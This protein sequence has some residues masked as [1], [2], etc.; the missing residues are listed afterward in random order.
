[1]AAA[2]AP[3]ELL[4]PDLVA[5]LRELDGR[6]LEQGLESPL[7]PWI[8]VAPRREVFRYAGY[9]YEKYSGLAFGLGIDRIAL[10]RHSI[11]SIHYL[12]ENDL[13]FLEQF[14]VV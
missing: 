13:R 2:P 11:P 1:M 3:P 9:D 6:Y 7:V 5:E 4:A 14:P 12:F 8:W 10:V